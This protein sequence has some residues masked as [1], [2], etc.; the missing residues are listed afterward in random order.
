[1]SKIEYIQKK[2]QQKNLFFIRGFMDY[3]QMFVLNPS[4]FSID[5]IYMIEKVKKKD[6]LF[7]FDF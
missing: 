2:K 3:K 5:S 4:E 6:P 1:M 7:L